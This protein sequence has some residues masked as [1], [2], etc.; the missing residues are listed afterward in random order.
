VQAGHIDFSGSDLE[1]KISRAWDSNSLTLG[2][3]IYGIFVTVVG[4]VIATI[5][6]VATVIHAVVVLALL[7]AG[8]LLWAQPVIRAMPVDPRA[9]VPIGERPRR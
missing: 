5:S 3:V 6:T 1:L 2:G 9:T 8:L 7:A 4:V